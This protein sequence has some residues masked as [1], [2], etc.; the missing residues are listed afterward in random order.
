[1]GNECISITYRAGKRI[2]IMEMK[3]NT[4]IK[5]VAR[6]VGVVILILGIRMIAEG[7]ITYVEQHQQTDWI[8]IN[9][10]VTDV[11]SRLKRTKSQYGQRSTVYDITYEYEVDEEIYSDEIRSQPTPCLVG[12]DIKVKYNPDAPEEST[13]SLSPSIGDLLVFA[14]FGLI[15]STLGFF[16]SGA[17]ILLRRLNRKRKLEE[18]EELPPEEYIEFENEEKK[19]KP[20][21]TTL[22]LRIG[23]AVIVV[24]IILLSSKLLPGVQATDADAFR[25]TADAAGY[26]TTDTTEELR[27]EWRVGSMLTE[28]V[29]FDNGMIRMDFCVMDTVDSSV[30]LYNGMTLPIADGEITDNGGIIHEIYSVENQTNYA[31]KIRIRDTIIYVFS[32]AE[33]KNFV[34]ELLEAIGYWKN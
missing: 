11:S 12:D 19:Q 6:I 1:M 5:F 10:E 9:A 8:V 33:Y 18:Q 17:F 28:A 14:I 2:M 34:I 13:A 24:S 23:L 7:A 22:F 4:I 26:T 32:L 15:F 29:S 27:Q 31:A 30:S 16:L 20:F 25:E 3:R 21:I